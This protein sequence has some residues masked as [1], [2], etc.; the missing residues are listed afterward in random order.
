MK[1]YVV[2]YTNDYEEYPNFSE[3][4][5]FSTKEK[6]EKFI[7]NENKEIDLETERFFISE[8]ELE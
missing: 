2:V 5:Y 3:I 6:A 4:K 8:K 7:K 1:I